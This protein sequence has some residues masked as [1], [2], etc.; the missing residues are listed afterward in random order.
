M[1]NVLPLLSCINVSFKW[2]KLTD[3]EMGNSYS[4]KVAYGSGTSS[5]TGSCMKVEIVKP[6]VIIS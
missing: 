6:L 5:Q 3:E 1:A 2:F 4:F